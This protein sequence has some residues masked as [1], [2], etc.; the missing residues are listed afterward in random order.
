MTNL[1]SVL[2]S[3][4]IILP[5]KVHIVKAMGFPVVTFRCES[6]TIKKAEHQRIYVFELLYCRRVL[7]VLWT[8]RRSNQLILKEINLEYLLEALMLK[9][10]WSSNTLGRWYKEPTLWK[11]PW[12]WERLR[13]GEGDDRGWGDWMA[14]LTRW[15]LVWANSGRWWRTGKP[16]M[17]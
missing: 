11:R 3:R 15:T 9:L 1:D 13:A 5:T 17:L 6:W 4:D 10:N 7:R 16:G 8:A 14:A 12:C 2:K